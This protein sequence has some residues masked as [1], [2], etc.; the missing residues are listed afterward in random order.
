MNPTSI[1]PFCEL[2]AR[3]IILH[4][5]L[6]LALLDAY[7]VTHGHALVIPRRHVMD[8]WGMTDDE[9]A[10]CH[11]LLVA[12]RSNVL[13]EDRS[14]TGFNIGLNAGKS[15][16]QTI[17]HCHYHLIPRRDGDSPNPRGGVRH[18]FPD[19]ANYDSQAPSLP[20]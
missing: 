17:F 9:R 20:L 10:A 15:A 8:Y 13:R 11:D 16:G 4:N 12:M 2:P 3:R 19:K 6:A 5:E 1:C 18:V 7:P 14:V